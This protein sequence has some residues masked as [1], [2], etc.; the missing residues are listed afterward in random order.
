MNAASSF[1]QRMLASDKLVGTFLKTPT[2]HATE[3]LGEVGYD[4]VVIDQEHAPFD[5]TASDIVLMAARA[6]GTPALVRVPGPD[7]ILSVLDRRDL[8]CETERRFVQHQ[9][10]RPRHQRASDGKHLL[11]TGILDTLGDLNRNGLGILLVEQKAPLA[12]KL[13]RRVYVLS[14]GRLRAELPA[15]EIKSYHDL[16]RFYFH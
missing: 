5:R 8:R 4:F 9:Q 16:T 15:H 13:A 3:I 1:R 6:Q 2:S 14:S 11:L 7:A 10:F 12:L